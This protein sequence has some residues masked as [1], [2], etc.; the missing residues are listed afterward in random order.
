MLSDE[1]RLFSH[2]VNKLVYQNQKL[3][4]KKASTN[5]ERKTGFSTQDRSKQLD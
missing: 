2:L 4:L 3:S 5:W 1:K